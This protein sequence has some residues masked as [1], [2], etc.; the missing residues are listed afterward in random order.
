MIVFPAD[1][2]DRHGPALNEDIFLLEEKFLPARLE[3]LEE[4]VFLELVS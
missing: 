1:L 4:R 2:F 3:V